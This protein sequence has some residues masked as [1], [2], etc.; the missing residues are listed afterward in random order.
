[1]KINSS[2]VIVLASALLII[3]THLSDCFFPAKLRSLN[4]LS[5]RINSIIATDRLK[6]VKQS[7]V[8]SFK[9]PLLDYS[10]DKLR[11]F[12]IKKFSIKASLRSTITVSSVSTTVISTALYCARFQNNGVTGA[13]SRRKKELISSADDM[14]E[15]NDIFNNVIQPTQVIN[16]YLLF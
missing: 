14:I 10:L 16:G 7:L 8:S 9:T 6:D 5:E 11:L 12:Y 15:Y 13:C 4:K 3:N 1:M 2:I